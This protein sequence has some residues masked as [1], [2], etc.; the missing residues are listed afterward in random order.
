MR[1]TPRLIAAKKT[2][3]QELENKPVECYDGGVVTA[4]WRELSM[5]MGKEEVF[6]R[7]QSRVSWLKGG[8]RN[9]SFFHESAS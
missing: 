7:Q 9:T 2:Q 8:D 5:L 4:L 1:I 6:W 3:L